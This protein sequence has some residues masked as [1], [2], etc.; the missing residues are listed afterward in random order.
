MQLSHANN[1]NSTAAELDAE[2]L[3][4]AAILLNDTNTAYFA[5]FSAI[6]GAANYFYS[7]YS[8]AQML[9]P[10][11][12]LCAGSGSSLIDDLLYL[13]EDDSGVGDILSAVFATHG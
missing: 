10:N 13:N 9:L 5:A 2:E 8:V 3:K 12:R 4:R 1:V 11:I 6:S 7:F